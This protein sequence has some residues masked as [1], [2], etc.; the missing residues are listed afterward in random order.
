MKGKCSICT[1]MKNHFLYGKTVCLR[2]DEL[3]F[4]IEI[5]C[6]DERAVREERRVVVPEKV[7]RPNKR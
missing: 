3:L 7:T 6:D 2:C 4:D 1:E 5:E